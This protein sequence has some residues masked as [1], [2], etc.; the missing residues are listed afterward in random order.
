[1]K[2]SAGILAYRKRGELEV[3]LVHPGGPFYKN[4]DEG[5]WSIPKGEYT[6][7]EALGVAKKEFT[8]ETGNVINAKDFLRLSDI[9]IKSGKK[10]SAWAVECDFDTP[11]LKSNLF[12]MEWPPKSG[13]MASFPEADK[14]EWHSMREAR[15]KIHP[16]QV[17]FLDQLEIIL[18]KKS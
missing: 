12:E 4:K 17:G 3:L 16:G 9:I 5:V 14:A 15:I 6:T 13:K 18:V 2:Q 10:I 11:F 1:M 7:E 8:E